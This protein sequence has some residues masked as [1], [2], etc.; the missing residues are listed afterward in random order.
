MLSLLAHYTRAE[1]IPSQ[2]TA[3]LCRT[4]LET[5]TLCADWGAPA[6]EEGSVLKHMAVCIQQKEEQERAARPP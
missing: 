6:I 4:A 2:G 1:N 3:A 5:G